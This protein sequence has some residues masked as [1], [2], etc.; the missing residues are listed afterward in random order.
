ME[1]P[2]CSKVYS[3][4]VFQYHAERCVEPESAAKKTESPGVKATERKK[5]EKA[6]TAE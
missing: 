1:C 3:N 6:A 2:V 4:D 5:A